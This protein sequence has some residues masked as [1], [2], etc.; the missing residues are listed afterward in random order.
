MTIQL[1]TVMQQRRDTAANWNSNNPT[2]LSGE[3]GY[4]TDTGYLKIG[5]GSTAWTSLAYVLG[6]KVSAYPLA[7]ADIANDAITADKLAHTAV[8]AG[9][10]TTVDITVDAQGRI[11]AAASG[12][13]GTSEIAD[14]SITSA[15]LE[16]NITIAGNL[17]VSGTTTT[18]NSTTLT[19]DDKNIELGSVAT[20]SDTTA[21]GGGVTLK[22]SSDHTIT[23]TN[24]TDSWDF[25]E[26]VNIASGKEFRIAGT[27]VLDATSLGSAVVTSSLTSVGTISTGVWNG[28][29]IAAAYIADDA[30]TADKLNNT[31]VTAG[32]YT[33][34]DI[35][36]D[37][38]GRLT[39]AAS[40]TIGTAE[41]A[42]DAITAAKLA[43]TAVTAGSYTAAD[44]T[45][46]AQGRITAAGSGTISTGEIADD[47]VT[48][49]KLADTSVTA[50]SY[51]LSS[52][53]VDAQGR[54]T[55][56]SSNTAVDADK[57]TEG[58]TEA[59]V[60]DTG[61]DGHFKV[62]TEGTERIRVGPAG[63]VGIAGANYGTSGQVLTSGGASALISWATPVKL[64]TAQTFTAAQTF[65]AGASD[66]NGDLRSVPQN[67]QTGAYTLVAGDVGKHV[68][69]TT[70]G[71][72]VPSGVFSAGDAV[73][74]YND[75]GSD[76]TVTQ[77]SSATLRLAGDGGTGNKTLA[78]YGLCTVLCVASNEF[79][80]AGTGLS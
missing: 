17:T 43:D 54:I 53:T 24:S 40:G 74:I 72:T 2:L 32:S 25:S 5:D 39:A 30:I 15:K 36:V 63:Q 8:T 49:A 22:G 6:T 7:T 80:I 16:D 70:G 59:E 76:Q 61:S 44:I 19:V 46:D 18:V 33:A 78:G 62:T 21:D 4:E 75:S 68:N 51:T 38:Q 67:S 45:V 27:K 66:S 12:T 47:A 14:G 10:Y 52:I 50:G 20:P 37:A 42:D 55:A 79:V 26:H 31:A 34:A 28:T 3:I 64:D 23:W 58:N 77:G 41:I 60:V 71:V 11:T 29:Q 73:S 13:I 65:D 57:I 69:I 9:S 56:A 35:T 48:A 1:T